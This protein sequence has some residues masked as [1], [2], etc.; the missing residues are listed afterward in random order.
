MGGVSCSAKFVLITPLEGP[1]NKPVFFEN[2][3]NTFSAKI[4]Q[5]PGDLGLV[6]WFQFKSLDFRRISKDLVFKNK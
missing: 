1:I 2:V 6:D 5:N 4:S 3:E